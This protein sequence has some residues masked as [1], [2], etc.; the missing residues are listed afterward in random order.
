MRWNLAGSPADIMIPLLKRTLGAEYPFVGFT[1][2]NKPRIDSAND[3]FNDM[4]GEE[5]DEEPW[6]HTSDMDAADLDE[7]GYY[8]GQ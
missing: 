8:C 3:K 4:I 6:Q 7:I 5:L 1:N 2:H